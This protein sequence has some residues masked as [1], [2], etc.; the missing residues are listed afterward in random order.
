MKKNFLTGLFYKGKYYKREEKDS[1]TAMFLPS[2]LSIILCAI[3]LM[4]S[5]W[6]WFT[7]SECAAT[8]TIQA[9]NYDVT[10]VIK[11]DDTEIA[12]DNGTYTLEKGT[13]TVTLTASG[14][15]TTGYCVLDF[16]NDIKAYTEQIAK[17]TSITLT[18]KTNEPATLEITAVWGTYAGDGR[19]SAE[20]TYGKAEE[21]TVAE[22]KIETAEPPADNTEG[23]ATEEM[24]TPESTSHE[25]ETKETLHTVAEGETLYLIAQQYNTTV[26]KLQA[27]NNIENASH[28]E[29]GDVIKIP[30]K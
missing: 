30:I 23:T 6:A 9:A 14:D 5:T 10:A 29:I 26:E 20:Y 8:Q 16:G 19:I 24:T 1:L 27:Y 17:G 12:A 18:L 11:L 4:G 7:A 28:I 21:I 13:Y 25:A 2:T 15:A 3:C 22:E